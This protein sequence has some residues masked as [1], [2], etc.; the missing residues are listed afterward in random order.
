MVLDTRIVSSTVGATPT[1]S[2]RLRAYSDRKTVHDLDLK[3]RN[4]ASKHKLQHRKLKLSAMAPS[5]RNRHDFIGL[6]VFKLQFQP[7]G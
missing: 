6:L 2:L 5:N 1:V 7:V 3:I 4:D